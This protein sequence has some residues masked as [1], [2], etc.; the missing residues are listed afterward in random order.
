MM[1]LQ[2]CAF[3]PA[4][5]P[6]SINAT[7]TAGTAID[8]QP[9]GNKASHLTVLFLLGAITADMDIPGVYMTECE[10][11]GGSYSAEI[12]GS[13]IVG[14]TSLA[15]LSTDDNGIGLISIPLLGKRMRYLKLNVDPGA[16]ATLLAGVAI[17]SGLANTPSTIADANLLSRAVIA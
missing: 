17:L 7:L 11:S 14:S 5:V 10:T 3:A 8:T 2:N 12:T 6:Q 15:V 13:R 1:N 9:N 16:A 4:L